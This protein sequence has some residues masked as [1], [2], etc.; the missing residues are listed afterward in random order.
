MSLPHY[1]TRSCDCTAPKGMG[2]PRPTEP[3]KCGNRFI[4]EK[5]KERST[6]VGAVPAPGQETVRGGVDSS[7]PRRPSEVV[8]PGEK[9]LHLDKPPRRS[10]EWSKPKRRKKPPRRSEP[11]RDW[12]DARAKVEIEGRCRR[13]GGEPPHLEAAHLV[14]RKLDEPHPDGTKRLWVNPDR[15]V[16]LCPE[17]HAAF[18]AHRLDL[19]GHLSIEEQ[20]RAVA[21]C[22]GIEQAR[23]R[24][25]PSAYVESFA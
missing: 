16:P 11:K 22:G 18:D 1:V 6:G 13:C 2:Y 5:E 10:V 21:D 3:C 7:T 15:I 9:K 17:D 4:T 24:L 14:G 12:T 8:Q 23:R 19:L 25:A 20:L